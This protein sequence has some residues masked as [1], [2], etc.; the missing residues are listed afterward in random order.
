M[1][2]E[3]MPE[4]AFRDCMCCI[5]EHRLEDVLADCKARHVAPTLC[6]PC[7]R[8]FHVKYMPNVRLTLKELFDAVRKRRR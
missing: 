1:N 2:V 3:G 4:G 6:G 5:G 7:L 8:D